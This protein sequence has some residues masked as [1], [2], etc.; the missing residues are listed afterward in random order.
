MLLLEHQK[1][2]SGHADAH[3]Y[4]EPVNMHDHIINPIGYVV[5]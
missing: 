1:W 3:H 4:Q 5:V 2:I